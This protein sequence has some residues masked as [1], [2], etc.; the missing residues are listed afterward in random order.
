MEETDIV[1]KVRD[2]FVW[3]KKYT[4]VLLANAIYIYLF[5]LLTQHY[6]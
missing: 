4:L 6:A 3:K 5:Y 2:K 1:E